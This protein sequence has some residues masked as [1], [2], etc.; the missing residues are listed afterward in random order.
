M[1]RYRNSSESTYIYIDR[2][3]SASYSTYSNYETDDRQLR[4]T[5]MIICYYSNW[6]QYRPES[7]V[8]VSENIDYSLCAHYVHALA[9][10]DNVTYQIKSYEWNDEDLDNGRVSGMYV[11][12]L[13]CNSVC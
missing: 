12:R 9:V 1:S 6:A 7:W 4:N 3:E 11:K 10:L 5:R 13:R 8:Y 2:F